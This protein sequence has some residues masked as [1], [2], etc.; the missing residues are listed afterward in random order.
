MKAIILA[1]GYATRMHPLT[2][3]QPK[4]LLPLGGRPIIDYIIDQINTLPNVNEII[5]MSNHKFYADFEKWAEKH[6]SKTP[7]F[8]IDDGSMDDTDRLGAIGDI[9][10][11][12]QVKNISEDIVVIAGDNYFTYPLLEQYEFFKQ[13]NADT[14]CA[15]Q[16]ADR[17]QLKAFAV[18]TLADDGKVLSLTEKPAEPQ[19]DIA[20]F[21][22]YFYQTATLPLFDEYFG[23]GLNTDQPGKFPEW[24]HKKKDIYAYMMNGE[25]HDIGT[26]EA[27]E[28]MS[29]RL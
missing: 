27:Y 2:E 4:A 29:A 20:V 15:T 16:I 17:E 24:L 6:T 14:L 26:I 7:I 28:A 21:A 18:A 12:I 11:A 5:V 3:N 9:Y 8:L 23:E 19:S 25:C 13:K 22:T 1:A 10:F